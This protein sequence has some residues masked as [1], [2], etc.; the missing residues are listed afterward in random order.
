M[1]MTFGRLIA[2]GVIGGLFVGHG[3]QKLFGWFGGPGLDGAGRTMHSLELRP[4]RR[5]AL[6]AGASE[7]AGGALLALGALTPVAASLITGTMVTAIRKVHFAKGPWNTQGG[8]EFNLAL[9][10]GV[11]ALVDCGPGSPSVDRSLGIEARGNLWTLAALAAGAAG[12]QLAIE[13]GR[14]IT[15]RD[16]ALAQMQQRGRFVRDAA[17][18]EREPTAPEAART[19]A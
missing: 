6:T 7:A 5:N 18:P 1:D 3:T 2:R 8:Y 13:A 15:E 10:A 9:I 19:G 4:G 16:E 11:A 17:A 12:S 14:R